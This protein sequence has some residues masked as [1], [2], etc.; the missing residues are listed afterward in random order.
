MSSAVIWGYIHVALLVLWV[1]AELGVFVSTALVRRE[2]AALVTRKAE[3]K[4]ATNI[5]IVS[6]VCFALIL[7]VGIELIGA[8]NV[9]PLTPG[10]QTAGWVTAALWLLIICAHI[11]ATGHPA[12]STLRHVDIFFKAIAGLGFV[13][14][15]LNSLATGAPIDETWFATKL[16]LVGLVFWAAIGVDLCFRPFFAPFSELEKYGATPER[17]EAITRAVNQTLGAMV[18]LYLLLAAIAFVGRVKTF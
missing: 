15:G 4:V 9:Y 2:R 16:F 6:R 14:Y 8:I 11:R 3:L 10:L 1:G 12:A 5:H 13:V 7:P 18:V 17:E